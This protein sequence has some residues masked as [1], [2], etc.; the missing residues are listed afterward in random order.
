MFRFKACILQLYEQ[1]MNRHKSFDTLALYDV[2]IFGSQSHKHLRF[3][4]PV[5]VRKSHF[6]VVP[7]S[8]YYAIGVTI[9]LNNAH[10]WRRAHETVQ[11]VQ[12]GCFSNRIE[13]NCLVEKQMSTTEY[14]VFISDKV[15]FISMITLSLP[16]TA[17]FTLILDECNDTQRH[18]WIHA[19]T[20]YPP[21]AIS[22]LGLH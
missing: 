8:F 7:H 6:P 10:T 1:V 20:C 4:T 19:S 17:K 18:E 16:S 9:C 11:V 21:S 22:L 13:H 14:R 15:V 2:P 5:D 3:V 12:N